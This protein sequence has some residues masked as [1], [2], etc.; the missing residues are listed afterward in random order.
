MSTPQIDLEAMM[1]KVDALELSDEQKREVWQMAAAWVNN[2]HTE[3]NLAGLASLVR[4]LDR[5][6]TPV[7]TAT[8]GVPTKAVRWL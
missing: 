7:T 6:K 4:N 8:L 1:Q 2:Q 5:I 3:P